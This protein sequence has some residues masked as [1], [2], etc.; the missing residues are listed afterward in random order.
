MA[1]QSII[2]V[3]VRINKSPNSQK[4]QGHYNLCPYCTIVSQ[5]CT[6]RAKRI[7]FCG[8]LMLHSAE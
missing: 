6:T 3:A 2:N 1:H 5:K 4:A 8:L 7:P